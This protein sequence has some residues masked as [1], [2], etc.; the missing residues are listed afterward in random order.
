MSPASEVGGDYYDI[1]PAPDGCWLGIGDVSGH[2]LT[3][4]LVALMVQSGVATA[5]RG[6]ATTSM[7]DLIAAVK[8]MLVENIRKRIGGSDHITFAL[9]R[10][11]SDGRI[12]AAG[13]HEDILI[14]PASGGPCRVIETE[15]MW[16]GIREGITGVIRTVETRL[17]EGD[18]L[19]LFT[20]GIV[21]ARA[22]REVFG[23]DRFRRA[24]ERARHAPLAEIKS[25]VFDELKRF[26]PE[27]EDDVTLLLARRSSHPADPQR[28]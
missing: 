3:A 10:C 14:V 20:D 19:D 26:C 25:A 7:E 6:A 22:N 5:V 13:E 15:G 9:V 8:C 21:E 4:G 23:H 17:E 12:E 27:P 28:L 11:H 18:V 16:L 24:L 1:I 2:G